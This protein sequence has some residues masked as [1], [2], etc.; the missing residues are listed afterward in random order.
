MTLA[1]L[2]KRLEALEKE[3]AE[4]RA[5]VTMPT[6]ETQRHWWRDN[7]GKFANDP[8]FEEIVRLG[9]EYRESLH[10]DRQKKKKKTRKKAD[11]GS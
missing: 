7:A 11:A 9:R 1:E 4:L 6:P 10:P 5:K 3:V 8:V 2:A